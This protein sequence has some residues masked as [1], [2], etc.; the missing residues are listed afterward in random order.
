MWD[1][2]ILAAGFILLIIGANYLVD[3]ASALAAKLHIS[4]LVIGLTIVAFGTSS[5]ELVVSIISS[6]QGNSEISIGN[7][8]GSNIFNIFII[9]GVSALIIPLSV[10]ST[11]TWIEIPLCLL[12]ALLVLILAHS[13]PSD[14]AGYL[15]ISRTDGYILLIMFL[16]FA[17]YNYHLSKTGDVTDEIKVSDQSTRMSVL[18]VIAGLVMLVGGGR[19]VVLSSVNIAIE[20]GVPERLIGLTIV[21]TGTSLPELVTSV[22]AALKGNTDIAIGNIVGSNIFNVF[23]V[24]GISAVISPVPLVQGTSIDL[25]VNIFASLLLFAFIF[26]GKGRQIERLEGL[27][28]IIAYL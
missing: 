3:N 28:F 26:T 19:L 24:L 1:L 11:T 27:I 13:G 10:K 17:F 6:I 12:S 22:V 18:M 23:L 2:I 15:I 20:I 4:N 21:A 8:V 25:L 7:V 16:A 9:L 14:N 5:P